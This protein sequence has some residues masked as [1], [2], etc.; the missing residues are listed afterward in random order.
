MDRMSP[1]IT[2]AYVIQPKVIKA[3]MAGRRLRPIRGVSTAA[4]MRAARM[5]GRVMKISMLS[6]VRSGRSAYHEVFGR[7]YWEDL[8]ANPEIARQFDALMGPAGH[9]VHRV[10]QVAGELLLAHAPPQAW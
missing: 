1:R 2:R 6:A 4:R 9:G 7:P 8:E 10:P 3:M 5:N